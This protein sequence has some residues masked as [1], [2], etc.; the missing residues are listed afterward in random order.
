MIIVM[1]KIVHKSHGVA[2]AYPAPALQP[3]GL[4][5]PG[6][7]VGH[8]PPQQLLALQATQP[9][10]RRVGIAKGTVEA[11]IEVRGLRQTLRC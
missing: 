10:C 9:A 1:A 5:D 6:V 4:V 8:P 7:D 3:K 11:H 2:C